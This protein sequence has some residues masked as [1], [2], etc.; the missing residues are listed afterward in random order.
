[1]CDEPLHL[2][3]SVAFFCIEHHFN[4]VNK[5]SERLVFSEDEGCETP[6]LLWS[7]VDAFVVI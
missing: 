5:L 1:M 3:Y 7:P 2:Q 4:G 6:A